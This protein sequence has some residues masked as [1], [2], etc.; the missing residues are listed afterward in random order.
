MCDDSPQLDHVG[1]R[2]TGARPPAAEP[3]RARSAFGRE[4]GRHEGSLDEGSAGAAR[5]SIG[6]KHAHVRAPWLACTTAFSR[7]F[8]A[9]CATSRQR[10]GTEQK[11]RHL[12]HSLSAGLRWLRGPDT[13]SVVRW[14]LGWRW[15][16]WLRRSRWAPPLRR[17]ALRLGLPPSKKALGIEQPAVHLI[18]TILERFDSTAPGRRLHGPLPQ[19]WPLS[20]VRGFPLSPHR[21]WPQPTPASLRALMC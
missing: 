6:A 5:P 4:P 3:S 7:V 1:G 12:A 2:A 13:H 15:R 20:P 17:S 14:S 19:R 16:W 9:R 11:E 21:G 18:P 8:A 10:Q